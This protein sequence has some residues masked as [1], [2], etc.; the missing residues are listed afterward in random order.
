MYTVPP[1]PY[2][3]LKP[4]CDDE[5]RLART[6]FF[7]R[8]GRAEDKKVSISLL[9]EHTSCRRRAV[10]DFDCT[11]QPARGSCPS[12]LIPSLR[13]NDTPSLASWASHFAQT[14]L[15]DARCVLS[16]KMMTGLRVC[17]SEVRWM[18]HGIHSIAVRVAKKDNSQG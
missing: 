4:A 12:M 3:S 6:G 5:D 15:H 1:A 10:V 9:T 11:C 7:L 13:M 14:S 17:M 2:K 8:G 16:R 18:Y